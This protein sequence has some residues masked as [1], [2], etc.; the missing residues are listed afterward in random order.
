MSKRALFREVPS[1]AAV[2]IRKK[3]LILFLLEFISVW[4]CTTDIHLQ[5]KFKILTGVRKYFGISL[6]HSAELF[7]K[8]M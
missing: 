3:F 8:T 7:P 2:P 5:I 4:M 6:T 1:L